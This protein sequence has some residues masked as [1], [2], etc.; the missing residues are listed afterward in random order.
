MNIESPS[1]LELLG[2][3]ASLEEFARYA[4]QRIIALAMVFN[5]AKRAS[6]K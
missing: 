6:L 5:L 4:A 3:G 1:I 2:K